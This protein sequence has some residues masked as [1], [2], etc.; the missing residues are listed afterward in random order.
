MDLPELERRYDQ[1]L[2]SYRAALEETTLLSIEIPCARIAEAFPNAD[3]LV[4]D[5]SDQGPHLNPEAVL[6]A[7]GEEV[8]EAEDLVDELW[9]HVSNLGEDNNSIW[10]PFVTDAK[11]VYGDG[12]HLSI[13]QTLNAMKEARRGD[14]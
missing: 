9:N 11:T 5:W 2:E 10:G 8:Q 7:N 3:L 14:V 4:L 6:D 12:Y 1:A 13:R